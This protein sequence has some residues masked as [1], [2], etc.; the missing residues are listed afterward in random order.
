MISG[1]PF[2]LGTT[3]YIVPDSLAANAR[4]L[5]DY[6][7]DVEL[8][9]F[10]L[11]DGRN[12]LP[13]ENELLEL[14]QATQDRQISYTVHLPQDLRLLTQDGREHPSLNKARKVIERAQKLDPHA[15]VTHIDGREFQFG[16]VMTDLPPWYDQAI[17]ALQIVGRWTGSLPRLAVENLDGFPPEFF[18][19]I[20]RRVNVKRCL[21]VGHLWKDGHDPLPFLKRHLSQTSVIHLHGVNHRD[22][23]SL[24]H[25]DPAQVDAVFTLLLQEQY[26]GVVTLEVFGEDDFL[27]SYD[28]VQQSLDRVYKRQARDIE[29]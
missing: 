19:P 26:S 25:Q 3:S 28:A 6:V 4:W 2:R 22:H 10:D 23:V 8:V 29:N 24:A 27:T 13:D 14:K 5:A 7:Q 1:L 9:L 12:N 20:I 11:E 17:E 15:Y 16:T 18:S 21:D